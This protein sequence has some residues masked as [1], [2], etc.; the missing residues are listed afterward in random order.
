MNE[1]LQQWIQQAKQS[2]QNDD[3]IRQ[4]LALSGWPTPEIDGALSEIKQNISTTSSQGAN[5][6]QLSKKTLITVFSIIALILILGGGYFL[7]KDSLFKNTVKVNTTNAN[8]S[9]LNQ[10]SQEDFIAVKVEM[11]C[12]DFRNGY[13]AAQVTARFLAGENSEMTNAQKQQY[14]IENDTI[15]KKHGFKS[16]DEVIFYARALSSEQAQSI[17]NE[18]TSRATAANCNTT[19]NN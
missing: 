8:V 14:L 3:Q 6:K 9:I 11:E 13:T 7:F 5:A 18:V 1:Q 17:L 4:Q 2:G 12:R 16:G 15:A 10:Y 19:D